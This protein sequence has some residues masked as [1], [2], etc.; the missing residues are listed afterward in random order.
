MKKSV[1]QNNLPKKVKFNY[2]KKYRKYGTYFLSK[3]VRLFI[4]KYKFINFDVI[5]KTK[6]FILIT[7][8]RMMFGPLFNVATMPLKLTPVIDYMVLDKVTMKT[9][10]KDGLLKYKFPQFIASSGA[11][12]CCSVVNKLMWALDPI[13]VYRDNRILSTFKLVQQKLES[14]QSLVIMPEDPTKFGQVVFKKE[15][16]QINE[17]PA[18]M[19]YLY[20]KKMGFPINVYCALHCKE[21][22][23]SRI[24]GPLH[25]DITKTDIQKE[26]LDFTQRIYNALKTL[27]EDNKRDIELGIVKTKKKYIKAEKKE[28]KRK[29]K[30]EQR[31]QK[32]N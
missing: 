31:K 14:G 26:R 21:E 17:G 1:E 25:F 5:D 16:C 3:F 9:D 6:P 20:H 28:Q 27:E 30:D 19:A 10:I 22:R 7:N 8:H 4:G 24:S 23:V 13:P 32:Q 12:F 11:W 2:R 29:L 15:V 18:Q